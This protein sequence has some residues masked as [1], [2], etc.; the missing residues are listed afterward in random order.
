[1]SHEHNFSLSE[2]QNMIRDTVRKFVQDVARPAALEADEHR[3]FLAANLSGL[4][5]LGLLGLPVSEESGGLGMGMLS[6]AI[7]LEEISKACG[8]TA[9]LMLTQAGLCGKALEGLEAASV[10]LGEIIAGDKTAG[11]IGPEASISAIAAD[12]GFK[13]SGSAE[14]VLAAAEADVLLL[15]GATRGA[16][17]SEG[18][19]LLLRLDKGQFAA[20]P[21]KIGLRYFRHQSRSSFNHVFIVGSKAPRFP[22]GNASSPPKVNRRSVA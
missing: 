21:K 18:E 5:E 4:A 8:S 19:A 20:E 1:M 13:L 7:A 11:Y 12:D 6:F 22:R 16:Q 14:I 9:A 17:T 2:E 3:K 10:L 15:S